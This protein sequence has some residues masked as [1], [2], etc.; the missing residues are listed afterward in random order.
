MIAERHRSCPRMLLPAGI[1]I[2][3]D[4]GSL[5]KNHVRARDCSTPYHYLQPVFRLCYGVPLSYEC[6]TG[7]VRRLS[8]CTLATERHTGSNE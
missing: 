7:A 3:S 4:S 2:V 6:R 5:R 8:V 1:L